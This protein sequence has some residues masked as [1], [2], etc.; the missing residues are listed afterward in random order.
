MGSRPSWWLLL[1][2]VPLMIGLFVLDSFL[3]LPLMGHRFVEGGIVVLCFGLMNVWVRANYAALARDELSGYTVS[4]VE[5]QEKKLS[6]PAA[7]QVL[8]LTRYSEV[9]VKDFDRAAN[10]ARYN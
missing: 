6:P 7:S 4:I 1:C 9:V 3:D 10:E 2:I 5:P 8:D